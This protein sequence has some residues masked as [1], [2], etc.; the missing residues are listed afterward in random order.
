MIYNSGIPG[1]SFLGDSTKK[2]K[3]ANRK[4]QINMV[5]SSL[6]AGSETIMAFIKFHTKTQACP[7]III[8]SETAAWPWARC[9]PHTG[10]MRITQNLK[11]L[12]TTSGS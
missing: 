2:G 12:R 8:F 3:Q 10:E 5:T 7:N 1:L 9:L 11:V 6:Q 4:P